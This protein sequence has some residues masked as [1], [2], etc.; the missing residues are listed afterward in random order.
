MAIGKKKTF[1]KD[2][3][4]AVKPVAPAP[5]KVEQPK[6]PAAPIAAKPVIAAK[7]PVAAKPA[8][9]ASKPAAGKGKAKAISPEEHYRMVQEAAYYI[10]EKSG[11]SGDSQQFW[12]QA[13]AQIVAMLSK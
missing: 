8:A 12:V 5:V 6:A 2:K 7:P 9:A 11:F 4:E 10:A 13:E 1:G 3:V